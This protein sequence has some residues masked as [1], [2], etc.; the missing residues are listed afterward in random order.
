MAGQNTFPKTWSKAT[1]IPFLKH[2]KNPFY[3]DSYRPI[4]LT[5]NLCKIFRKVVNERL[6]WSIEKSHKHF[7]KPVR[8]STFSI[9][10][11]STSIHKFSNKPII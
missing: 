4:R 6:I 7:L 2:G 11:Q 9:Y 10:L 8:L 5:S 1:I 3:T